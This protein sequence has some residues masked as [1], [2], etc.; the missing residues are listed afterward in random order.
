MPLRITKASDTIEVKNLTACI[1]AVPGVGKTTLGFTAESPLL[2]DFDRGS[3]R[4]GNRADVVQVETWADVTSIQGADLVDY[5]TVVV[6]T[7]G[8]ALDALTADIIAGNPKMGRG[9]ALT[10]QG[11]GE[12]KARFIAWTK[13]IRGFGLEVLLLAHS[14]EQRQGDDVIERLDVQ[15]GSKNEIYKAAD[16]MGRIY[17]AGGKRMLNFSPTDTAFGKNPAQLPPLEVPNFA[18]EPHFFGGVLSRIKAELN[19]QSEAQK[20]A[21][22]AL[23]DWKTKIEE[24]STVEQFNA[25]VPLT[26]QADPAVRD[27][28]KRLL[29]KAAKEKG[30]TFDKKAN[31]FVAKAA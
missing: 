13:L 10:L 6:D 27:N 19:K 16:V 22:G 11:F 15:G 17:L 5:K 2:L 18:V 24:A 4:A 9:G 31:A 7:A 1:Y 21:A 25:L 8:R 23:A 29:T 30:V 14:D 12:L 28:V 20:T 26:Q 3:Y